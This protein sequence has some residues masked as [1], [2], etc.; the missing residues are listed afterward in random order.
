MDAKVIFLILTFS[1]SVLG[2][3]AFVIALIQRQVLVPASAASSI[4]GQGEVGHSE[5]DAKSEM[6]DQWRLLD[7]SAKLPILLFIVTSVIWLVL[8]SILGL[9]V[10]LKFHAP[11][12]S[13][14]TGVIDFWKVEATSSQYHCL[15]LALSSSTRCFNVACPTSDESS[16]AEH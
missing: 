2:M 4:F 5:L 12:V 1:I 14:N 9:L 16:F 13:W 10:S 3:L 11:R 8:G 6:S 7:Q 15:W